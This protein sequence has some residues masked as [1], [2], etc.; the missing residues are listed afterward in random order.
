MI[1]FLIKSSLSLGLLLGFYHL[2]LKP[3][4]SANFNRFF[5]LFSLIFSLVIPFL[6]FKIAAEVIQKPEVF[7]TPQIILNPVLITQKTD[8]WQITVI[9]IYTIV[10]LFLVYRFAKNSYQIL[11][12]IKTSKKVSFQKATL[13]LLPDSVLPHSFLNYIFLSETSYSSQNITTQLFEHELAHVTQK[14]T[15][16]ILIIEVLK[17]IFW[18]NPIFWM[19]KKA[20]QLNH[21][22]LADQKVVSKFTDVANYQM[23]LLSFSKIEQNHLL[24]SNINYSITKKRFLM[25][26]KKSN[27]K[28]LFFKKVAVLPLL[29]ALL[30]F[31]CFE[32]VA[33]VKKK[34][35]KKQKNSTFKKVVSLPK[36]SPQ[37]TIV[38][39]NLKDIIPVEPQ[40]SIEEKL[41][42][43]DYVFNTSEV[44]TS[45]Q[46]VGGFDTFF[47]FIGNNYKVPEE[48][49]LRGRVYISFIVENDGSLSNFKILR[50]IGFGTGA[51]AIRVLKLAPKWNPAKIKDK[52]VRCSYAL[53]ISLESTNE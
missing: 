6:N 21:E 20:I 18:F 13:V 36:T 4:N 37:K 19:Y 34:V 49:G 40:K 22:F 9:S 31:T 30:F 3:E 27:Q 10:A 17:T 11:S 52:S 12:K 14:H 53:P 16:D 50:D 1:D 28:L 46:P 29:A 24:T 42:T 7:A 23:Q 8:Y 25:M 35:I 5:L 15:L 26:T 2:V 39:N 33:Q 44:E 32:S 48:E 45:S 41:R 47:K 43:V 38:V 51:E